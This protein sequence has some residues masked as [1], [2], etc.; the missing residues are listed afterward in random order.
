[1]TFD[2]VEGLMRLQEEI[3]RF[4]GKP[5]FDLGGLSGANVFPPV[6]VFADEG[7]L[8]VRAEVPGI[9]PDEIQVQLE[10]GR[11]TIAGERKPRTEREPSY[12]RRERRHGRFARTI[13]L[14]RDLDPE[15]AQ[16]D[17]RNGMLTI[18]IPKHAAAKP[19]QI[20]VK[21]AS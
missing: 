6:N 19:R 13:Q 21:A 15:H 16:A 5:A 9:K 4:F 11:L 20:E 8:V 10:S 1:V 18:R 7:A 12:H 17:C 3:D 14:P 2:P